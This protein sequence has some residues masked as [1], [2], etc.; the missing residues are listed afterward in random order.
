MDGTGEQ[1]HREGEERQLRTLVE[2]KYVVEVVVVVV[3]VVVEEA[4]E[5]IVG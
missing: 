1:T 5:D 2:Q 3:V 4:A